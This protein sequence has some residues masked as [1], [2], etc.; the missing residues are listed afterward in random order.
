MGGHS[1]DPR[2]REVC[3]K[4]TGHAEVVE[5]DFDPEQVSFRELLRAFF[6][7]HNPTTLN[8]QGPDEGSQYRSAIFFHGDAQQAEAI[9]AIKAADASGQ[10]SQP[11][12]TEVAPAAS[13]WRAEEYHQQY[14]AKNGGGFCHV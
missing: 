12:V 4:T 3:S 10:W 8:R 2:Y 11:V 7:M 14:L 6:A 5:L 1:E 13:F 9:E